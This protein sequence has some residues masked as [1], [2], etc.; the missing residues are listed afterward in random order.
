MKFYS[1]LILYTFFILVIS[2]CALIFIPCYP[3]M[4]YFNHKIEYKNFHVYYDK[5]IPNQIYGILDVVD[6]L[7][8]KADFYDHNVRFKIFL[9]SDENKYNLFPFQFPDVGSGWAIPF[10]KNVFLYKSDCASN[11]TYNHVGHMRTLSTALAHELTHILVENKYFFKS[12]M[13]FFDEDCLSEFGL[14]WKEEGYAEYIAGGPSMKLEEGL[15]ML[16]NETI[17]EYRPHFEYFKYWLAV[18]YLIS[19]KQMSFQEILDA[20]LK[21]N[22]VLNEARLH[23][24]NSHALL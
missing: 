17:V 18:N 13:A 16:N 9:R 20:K 11:T 7:I 24:I 12:K 6:E 4:Y 10:I 23:Q 15:K 1:K 19:K 14:L 22:E 5:E 3:Q 21:L 2:F 8:R